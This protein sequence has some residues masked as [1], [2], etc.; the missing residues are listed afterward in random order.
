MT[1]DLKF[2][3]Y[4][5]AMDL[6]KVVKFQ[7]FIAS[8]TEDMDGWS[9]PGVKND[10]VG[11]SSV[12]FWPQVSFKSQRSISNPKKFDVKYLKNGVR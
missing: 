1:F 2:G 10:P 6:G 3:H 5:A 4:V 8:S 11:P 7:N 12:N 9:V